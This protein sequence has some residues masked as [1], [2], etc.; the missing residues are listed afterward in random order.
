MERLIL[1]I[2]ISD[3]KLQVYQIWNKVLYNILP[4]SKVS[5]LDENNGTPFQFILDENQ[6]ISKIITNN[7]DTWIKIE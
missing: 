1:D 4:E 3:Q 2:K 6:Q 7:R 5:F